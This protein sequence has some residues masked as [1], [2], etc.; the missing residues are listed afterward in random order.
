MVGS[1]LM[2]TCYIGCVALRQYEASHAGLCPMITFAGCM[3]PNELFGLPLLIKRSLHNMFALLDNQAITSPAPSISWSET[4]N[5]VP[6]KL[7]VHGVRPEP[8]VL[9]LLAAPTVFLQQALVYKHDLDS[10]TLRSAIQAV[11]DQQP[12]F[13]AKLRQAQVG[14]RPRTVCCSCNCP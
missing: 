2:H 13:A 8:S 12:L 4:C 5:V 6:C 7:D 1:L 10:A 11:V 3:S 14:R 9:D